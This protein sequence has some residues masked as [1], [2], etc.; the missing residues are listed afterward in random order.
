MPG[1]YEYSEEYFYDSKELLVKSER[2][3]THSY[4]EKEFYTITYSYTF[5]K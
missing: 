2:T 1:P 3:V 4:N 5:R